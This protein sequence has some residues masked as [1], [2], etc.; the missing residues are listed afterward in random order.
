MLAS[1]SLQFRMAIRE[2]GLPTTKKKTQASVQDSE[3][4]E[5]NLSVMF[6]KNLS[7]ATSMRCR[8]PGQ[9]KT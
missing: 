1:T 9:W 8:S 4:A 5:Q 6:E 3:F 2:K 7:F